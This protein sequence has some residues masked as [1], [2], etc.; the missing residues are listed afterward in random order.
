[1]PDEYLY[2]L[3]TEMSETGLLLSFSGPFSQGIIEELGAAIKGYMREGNHSK[4]MN[5]N[6]FSVFIE[7][8]QNIK[9]YITK[10]GINEFTD[11]FHGYGIVVIGREGEN[12]FIKSGNIIEQRDMEKLSDRIKLLQ[13]ADKDQLKKMY[14]SQIRSDPPPGSNGAGLG[15]IE[16]ARKAAKPLEY[17]F[18]KVDNNNYFFTLHVTV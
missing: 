10:R 18:T 2:K 9:N 11:P 6:V 14:K 16:M 13:D 5:M 4:S 1:M 7:Q 8:T 12:Y 17:S 3:A 15:L